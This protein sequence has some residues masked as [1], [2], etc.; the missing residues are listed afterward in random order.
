MT[1]LVK[2]TSLTLYP[3]LLPPSDSCLLPL[4][5]SLGTPENKPRSC[6][7]HSRDSSYAPSSICFWDISGH[8]SSS[9]QGGVSDYLLL[10]ACSLHRLQHA[11]Q[12]PSRRW[13]TTPEPQTQADGTKS[14]TTCDLKLKALER[15]SLG[16]GSSR[17]PASCAS[18]SGFLAGFL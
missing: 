14:F 13:T 6:E 1:V 17:A 12:S 11:I 7:H 8:M 18:T 3:N 16:A 5:L 2:S 15:L 9:S 10:A 4:L